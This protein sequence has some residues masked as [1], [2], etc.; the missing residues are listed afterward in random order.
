[1]GRIWFISLL[2]VGCAT[3]NPPTSGKYANVAQASTTLPV[4]EGLRPNVAFWI[5]IYSKYSTSEG[6]IHDSKYINKVYEIV[7]FPDGYSRGGSRKVKQAKT[8]IRATLLSIE[9]KLKEKKPL[10]A[11]EQRIHDLFA[12]VNEPQKF[13]AAAHRKR[14]RFQLGQKDRFL[15]GYKASGRFMPFMENVFREQGLPTELARLP[16]VESSFN[17]RARSK[18]GASGIW[19]FMRS[20]GRQFMTIREPVDERNDPYRATEAAAR[21]L[22]INYESLGKWPLAVT[23]YN[24]GRKGLMR[25]VRTTGSDELDEIVERYNGRAFGFAS[26]NFYACLVAAVEVEK[27]AEKYF[28]KIERDPPEAFVEVKLPL[29]V[30]T[31][32]L[33][34][35]LKYDI[36]MIESL[37]P[38]LS[39]DVWR[40]RVN[41]PAGYTLRLPAQP[42]LSADAQSK[43]FLDGLAQVRKAVVRASE[44]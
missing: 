41:I 7:E 16:F 4:G 33:S 27:D 13:V 38:A 6:L 42:E 32:E 28:G 5:D 26:S 37:N 18:V 39:S 35:Y 19:Q 40:G 31:R 44:E 34:Q 1:M 22:K 23:A 12:D 17:L 8:R 2:A 29:R 43:L 9:R 3:A 30:S 14:L 10:D 20:T 36:S 11:E 24:H 25:A 21:L 15:A